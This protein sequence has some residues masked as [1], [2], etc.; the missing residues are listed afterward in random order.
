MINE[1][2]D[3]L[4]RAL[5]HN[6]PLV[7]CFYVLDGISNHTRTW[8]IIREYGCVG[9]YLDSN[10]PRP[11]YPRQPTDGYRQ[12]LLEEAYED[13]G[14]DNWFVLMHGD[15]VW[16]ADPRSI[17]EGRDNDGWVFRL[18]FFVP[19]AEDGWDDTV[20]PLDQLH[21]SIGPGWPELRMFK[22]GPNVRYNPAQHFNVTP[23]GL[24][25]IGYAD[26][27]ILHYP[28][29]SPAVQ[30]ARAAMHLKSGFDPD[31]YR[32]ILDRDEVLWTPEMIAQ[33]MRRPHCE[34]LRDTRVVA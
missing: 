21:C 20:H 30:R 33:R 26:A 23:S 25:S 28:Y 34:Q 15:E 11:P 7:D 5:A 13:W 4:E 10:M 17:V 8:T 3:I 9:Y 22:G 6:A 16:T 14:H 24:G 31:N 27:E 1:E 29:R 12:F 32:H 2:N 19:L 18:P